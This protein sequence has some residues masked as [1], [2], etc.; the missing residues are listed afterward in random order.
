MTLKS[1]L[2]Y[3]VTKYIVVKKLRLKLMVCEKSPRSNWDVGLKGEI[4]RPEPLDLK[5]QDI[6]QCISMQHPICTCLC[7][8]CFERNSGI[9]CQPGFRPPK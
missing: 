1:I 4:G 2:L 5:H 9:E 6:V 8:I 7:S 3:K